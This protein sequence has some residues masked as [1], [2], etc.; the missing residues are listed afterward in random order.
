M[1]IVSLKPKIP[2]NYNACSATE[3]N[4]QNPRDRTLCLPFF[5]RYKHK[6]SIKNLLS[7]AKGDSLPY[8]FQGNFCSPVWFDLPV[9]RILL[10]AV[11]NRFELRC[12]LRQLLPSYYKICPCLP[13]PV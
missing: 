9:E 7:P 13:T 3:S 11:I 1:L 4:K 5:F 2:E 12:Q 10:S 6:A 8:W